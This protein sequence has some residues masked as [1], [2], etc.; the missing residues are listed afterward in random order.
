MD[1]RQWLRMNT[2]IGFLSVVT[3]KDHV[4]QTCEAPA[5]VHGWER[6]KWWFS[7]VLKSKWLDPNLFFFGT[8]TTYSGS[9]KN[10]W[11]ASILRWQHELARPLCNQYH[12]SQL[13]HSSLPDDCTTRKSIEGTCLGPFV[14]IGGIEKGDRRYTR[15]VSRVTVCLVWLDMTTL[16]LS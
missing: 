4:V 14:F 2:E 10:I 16:S 6:D 11:L 7:G 8:S 13:L 1:A 12:L 9:N 5:V 15:A 3:P